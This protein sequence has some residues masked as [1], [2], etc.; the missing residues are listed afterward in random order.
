MLEK[1]LKIDQK[2]Y[3]VRSSEWK[4]DILLE[5]VAQLEKGIAYY[6][7]NKDD[8]SAVVLTALAFAYD[9]VAKSKC[10]GNQKSE[11]LI[12]SEEIL[13]EILQKI[14]NHIQ[15]PQKAI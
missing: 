8:I 10:D 4:E 2:E 11:N 7:K 6:K 1:K 14:T 5:A 3:I 12:E 9:S 15:L 13:Q